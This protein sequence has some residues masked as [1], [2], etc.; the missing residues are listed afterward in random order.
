MKIYRKITED[1][2]NHILNLSANGYPIKTIIR[3][4]SLS[5][6]TIARARKAVTWQKFLA[7]KERIR[8]YYREKYSN[9]Q[10][11]NGYG[12]EKTKKD[13]ELVKLLHERNVSLENICRATNL[14]AR[15]VK[16]Y[17]RFRSYADYH[18]KVIEYNMNYRKNKEAKY[19]RKP[20]QAQP[21]VYEVSTTEDKGLRMVAEQ[22]NTVIAV[23]KAIEYKLPDRE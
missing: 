11:K 19:N 18:Q 12:R 22:L 10:A 20:T 23:L 17:L 3:E 15:T 2:F 7:E 1:Q 21:V 9:K 13:F 5:R 4:T 6:G 14:A 16:I 8:L